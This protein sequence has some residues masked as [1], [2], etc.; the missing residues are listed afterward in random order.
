[1]SSARWALAG[2]D[3]IAI[4]TAIKKSKAAAPRNGERIVI[5]STFTLTKTA[6]DAVRA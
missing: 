6:Q 4:E 1:M 3:Q 5:I 2:G